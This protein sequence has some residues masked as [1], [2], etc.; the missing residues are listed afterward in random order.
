MGQKAW[1]GV[2]DGFSSNALGCMLL[3]LLGV[4][5]ARESPSCCDGLRGIQV[6]QPQ[7]AATGLRE[8]FCGGEQPYETRL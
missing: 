8:R 7:A 5:L 1:I 3:A 2:D 4:S 6:F